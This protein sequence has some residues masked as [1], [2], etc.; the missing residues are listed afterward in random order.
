MRALVAGLPACLAL[1]VS[2]GDG[3][4]QARGPI[5]ITHVTVVPMDR[6]R[7]LAD[8]TVIVRD[9]VI[10]YLGAAHRAVL[11]DAAT[12]IDGRGKF[13]MPGIVDLHVHIVGS[14]EDRREILRSFAFNGVTTVLNLRGSPDHLALRED[15]ATGRVLGPTIYTAGPYINEPFFTTADAVEREV[16]AQKRAGY[17]FVK[18]HGDLS[19]E[20]YARLNAVGREVGI[21]IVGHSPR[22]LGFEAMFDERQYAVVHA[23]E[24]IYDRTSSSRNFAQLEPRIPEIAR[25]AARAKLWVMPNLTAFRNI[26][27]QIDNLDALLARPE[28]RFLPAAI[29]Q[30]WEPATNPYVRRFGKDMYPAIMARYA[31]LEKLTRG[32]RD[33]GVR[34]LVGT[35]ALNTGTIPGTSAHDELD[36]LVNAGLTPYEALRAATANAA[37]FLGSRIIGTVTVGKRADLL[38]LDAN[39][40]E[41]I[42]NTRKIAGVVLRG[43]WLA[44]SG[45]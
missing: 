32:F 25:A 39:P 18:M 15:V 19:R 35:D 8:Q 36:L 10:A 5:A 43:A 11:P 6:D 24:F 42:S 33:A 7:V 22:N 41:T 13:L 38:V 16:R 12:I 31:F 40:L 9:G 23:E 1:V 14:P 2:A 29:R 37:E 17:D 27:L 45:R 34:L 44:A 4:A 20:A 26:G 3:V 21:R 28:M 30:G